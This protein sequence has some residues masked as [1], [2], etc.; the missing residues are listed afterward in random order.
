MNAA[1]VELGPSLTQVRERLAATLPPA[2]Q[3]AQ[4]LLVMWAAALDAPPPSEELDRVITQ[5]RVQLELRQP[6]LDALGLVDA[7]QRAAQRAAHEC[8]APLVSAALR[9]PYSRSLLLMALR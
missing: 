1:V 6:V 2:G 4:G 5:G 3:R 9:A 7:A 8:G